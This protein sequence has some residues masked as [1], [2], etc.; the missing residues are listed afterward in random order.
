MK[1]HLVNGLPG[2]LRHLSLEEAEEADYK[3][4]NSFFFLN[5]SP[6]NG[7]RRGESDDGQKE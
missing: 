7:A 1:K 2:D 5:A 3:E 6:M 4:K